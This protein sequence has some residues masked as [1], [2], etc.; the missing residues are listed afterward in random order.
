MKRKYNFET[1]IH[2]KC[3]CRS[4][5]VSLSIKQ[6]TYVGRLIRRIYLLSHE[7]IHNGKNPTGKGLGRISYLQ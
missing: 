7:F 2:A 1:I 5:A 3:S 6:G 4:D